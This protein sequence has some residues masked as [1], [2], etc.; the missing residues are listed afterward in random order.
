MATDWQMPRRS[1]R[2]AV[3]GREFAIGEEFRVSL[4]ETDD[5]LER[6]DTA[7]DVEP[8]ERDGLI[9]AWRTRRP[10]P[11][12]KSTNAAHQAGLVE[13]FQQLT[14]ADNAEHSPLRFALALL[15]WRKKHLTLVE[16]D[17]A[18]DGAETWTFQ[19]AKGND[20]YTVTK[21]ELTEDAV[22]ELG[23]QLE[24]LLSNPGA[25]VSPP[26]PADAETTR[27]AS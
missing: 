26:A 7:L 14:D 27:A 4:Y 9:A 21:P 6:L 19:Q 17:R 3:S 16:T 12:T 8:P 11:D 1:N 13:L 24:A 25:A 20:Q 23:A 2:C 22:S 5:G 18:E 10:A 15:L